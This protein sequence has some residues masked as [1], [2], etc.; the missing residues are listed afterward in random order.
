MP[1]IREQLSITDGFS[2]TFRAFQNAAD[3]ATQSADGLN[4]SIDD[5]GNNEG[6]EKLI[7]S[8]DRASATL[9]EIANSQRKVTDETK[10]TATASANWLNTLKSVAASLGAM[11]LAKE[12]IEE[13]DAMSEMQAK[14]NTINDGL[15][16]TDQLNKMIFASAQR[17]RGSYQDTANLVARLGMNAAEA[18]SSNQ[19]AIT[20]AENLNKAF[21]IAG[22]SGQEQ[23]SVILQLSQALA[24]GALRGQEFNAVMSGAPNVI[25]EIAEYMGVPVGEMRDLAAEGKVTAEIVKNALISATDDINAQ[26]E[27]MPQTWGSII[28]SGKNYLIFGLQEAF[29]DWQALLN[30]EQFQQVIDILL[31]A[32]IVFARTGAN[33]LMGIGNA[34]TWVSQNWST[35][36]PIIM[37]A[38]AA[39]L[40]FKASSIGAMLA[41]V[42]GAI[43]SAAAWAVSHSW[44]VL[45]AAAVGGVV[46]MA[47]KAGL[48]FEDVGRFIGGVFGAL[49]AFVYNVFADL[50]N[51]VATFAEFFANVWSDPLG[52]VARMFV[53]LADVVLSTLEFIADAMDW[54]FGS[55]MGDTIRTW[56]N[57][58]KNW[59]IE[60][61]GEGNVH[62]DRMEKLDY[63]DTAISFGQ[64]GADIANGIENLVNEFTGGFDALDQINGQLEGLTDVVTDATGPTGE[65]ANVGSVGE[66]KGDV[67]LAEEDIKIL[68]DLAEMKYMQKV[69]LQTLAPNITVSIEEAA[70]GTLSAEDVASKIQTILIEQAAAHTATSH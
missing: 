29:A 22:A 42:K 4:S 39:M 57:D 45:I 10:A 32:V 62:V 50:W 60:N 26:F 28:Q 63:G 37:G 65:V 30:S 55:S 11:K 13:A 21:K 64:K 6:I 70:A 15:Q 69:E 36:K 49:Y 12:F 40:V 19:E 47:V 67:N 44:L 56:R 1:G 54:V 17:S 43:A 20:F 9:E 27:Q 53:S 31:N 51:V 34:I 58:M 23:A 5:L 14:L 35:L 41:N 3:S 61:F 52:S 24:G 2:Q 7:A 66:I 8:I 59:A 38:A 68:R 46:T 16:T 48:K 18:F 33:I 25:R